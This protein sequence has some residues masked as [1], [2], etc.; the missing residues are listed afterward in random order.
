MPFRYGYYLN[1]ISL[2]YTNNIYHPEH[3]ESKSSLLKY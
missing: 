2:K 1:A 3:C